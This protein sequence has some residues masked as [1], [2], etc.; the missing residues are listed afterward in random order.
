MDRIRK[1]VPCGWTNN[2]KNETAVGRQLRLTYI[3]PHLHICCISAAF[4]SQTGQAFSLGRSSPSP[5]W[6]CKHEV[7][8][9]PTLRSR[10][11]CSCASASVTEFAGFPAFIVV[12]RALHQATYNTANL[13]IHT[14]PEWRQTPHD[15]K[16]TKYNHNHHSAKLALHFARN[17]QESVELAY[18]VMSVTGN[19]GNTF[20]NLKTG[21]QFTF[22]GRQIRDFCVTGKVYEVCKLK[23]Q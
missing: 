15:K 13:C 14:T 3:A 10:W 2:R 8:W 16:F 21:H 7:I 1:T 9:A 11:P 18:L 20:G 19:T 5:P 22:C 6:Y 12:I 4:S 23:C 17:I